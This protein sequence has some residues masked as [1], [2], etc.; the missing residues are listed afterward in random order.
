MRQNLP[1]TQN[2]YPIADGAAIISRTDSA[3][4]ITFC[5]E[6]FVVASGFTREEVVGKPHNIVR[7]PDMPSEAY[8]D[9]WA[10]LQRGR[11]WSGIVKNRRKNGDFYWV[12]ATA[13]PIADGSGYMSVRIKASREE[14]ATAIALYARMWENPRVRLAEGRLL[15]TGLAATLSRL[16]PRANLATR[17][18]LISG[19]LSA[20]CILAGAAGL[21][22]ASHSREAPVRCRFRAVRSSSMLG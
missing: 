8:R 18:G 16:L 3:G 1:V 15:P 6:E 22:S 10:T 9:M 4:N 17:I 14:I 21:H 11:P 5:N 7:H 2:E 13:T 19:G 20:L 12:R